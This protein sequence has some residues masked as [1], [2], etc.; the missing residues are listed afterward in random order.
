[1]HRKPMLVELP[2]YMWDQLGLDDEKTY[3]RVLAALY[4]GFGPEHL[5]ELVQM[6]DND[7]EVTEILRVA[8]Q[9]G[10]SDQDRLTPR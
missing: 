1:M 7:P 9:L 5:R 3:Q 6:D 8:P 2:R 10:L 4:F